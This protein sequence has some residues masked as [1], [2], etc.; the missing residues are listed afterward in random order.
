MG[1]ISIQLAGIDEPPSLL[2][3]TAQSSI[4][5]ANVFISYAHEDEA[6]KDELMVHLAPLK[7][8][9]KVRSWQ[10]WAIE[11][12]VNWDTEI[13]QQLSTAEIILLLISPDFLASDSCYSV[14]MQQAVQH[15]DE[16]TT[17]IIPIILKPV[18]W[19]ATPFRKLQPLPEDARPI[20]S[21]ND[22]DNAWLN[23]VEGIRRAVDSFPQN[24]LQ[25]PFVLP[26]LDIATFT[27]RELELRRLEDLLITDRTFTGSKVAILTGLGG[28]G[29]SAL[30]CHFATIHRD[31]F[32][33]GV[34]GLRV[35]GQDSQIIARELAQNCGEG[36]DPEDE[37]D[38]ATLMHDIFAHR[39][40]LLILDDVNHTNSRDLLPGGQYCAVLVTTR[41]RSIYV[42]L[43]IPGNRVIDLSLLSIDAAREILRKFLGA[44]RVQAESESVDRIIEMTG[45]LPLA[46]QIVGSTLQRR[47]L[48]LSSY[49]ESL[50]QV[51]TRLQRL[52]TRDDVALNVAAAFNLSLTL[53]DE[54]KVDLFACL[55][56]CDEDEFS[57]QTAM[58]VGGLVDDVETQDLLDQ[59][60]QLSFL[61]KS[62]LNQYSFHPLIKIYANDLARQ[63]G[64]WNIASERY[65]RWK[66]EIKTNANTTFYNLFMT[67]S[68]DVVSVGSELE[69]T[70][71][72]NSTDSSNNGSGYLLEIPRDETLG[73][74]L[75]IL[76]NASGLKLECDNTASL[77]LDIN[78]IQLSS[79][80][81][82]QTAHFRLTALRP[83]STTI[84]AE[85]YRGDTFE[86]TLETTI[87]VIGLEEATLLDTNIKTEPRPVSQPDLILQVQTLWNETAS[88]FTFLYHLKSFRASSFLRSGISYQS[89][90]LSSSWLQQVHNLLQTKL[91]TLS[92]AL[93]VNGRF[94]LTSLGQYLFQY[95][96]PSDL[97]ADI[98]NLNR[99]QALTLQILVDRDAQFPWPLLHTGREFLAERFII[100]HWLWDLNNT[101]HYEFPVGTI[102]LAHY[103]AVEHPECWATLLAPPGAPPA[104][105]LTGGVLDDLAS[106]EAMRGL[107]LLRISQSTADRERRDAPVPLEKTA[108]ELTIDR[109]V[110][111]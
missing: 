77:S 84:I 85:I 111:P 32:P 107:H 52:Q 42:P 8:Q 45:G 64:L 98:C 101:K 11:S 41:D 26:Q 100:G 71:N 24:R 34:I 55:S 20:T 44:E 47:R 63:R 49:A 62:D 33:D 88:N 9:G 17:C 108:E 15:H 25:S 39:Q 57:S 78:E 28:S 37:R 79:P 23:V 36:I 2:K 60:Y 40:M 19:S 66:E 82:T 31:K 7:R 97:Q 92:D 94:H 103:D 70:T 91:E 76:L 12:G 89:R 53:L 50:Q 14:E 6:L 10:D 73:S 48:G 104:F 22:Q 4:K 69:V 30:A 96:L 46:L 75:N 51:K 43:E 86:T 80:I 99:Y 29:K 67:V 68:T 13:V 105:E 21:W 93:P 87:Q 95:L 1:C 90:S 38:T 102:N 3:Q 5:P 109:K 54:A 59:L 65:A 110:R 56:V 83:G 61:N 81:Q 27:G 72:L 16:G 35:D 18:N 106:T 58:A 74:E